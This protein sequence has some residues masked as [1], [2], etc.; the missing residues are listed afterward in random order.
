MSY[1]LGTP[2][3]L[4]YTTTESGLPSQEGY[5]TKQPQVSESKGE[6]YKPLGEPATY[7]TSSPRG[8]FT[9]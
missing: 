3:T 4:V 2:A 8:W 6:F 5:I 7:T 9:M 1:E